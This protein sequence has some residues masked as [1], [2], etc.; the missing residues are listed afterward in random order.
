MYVAKRVSQ[1]H[2]GIL[3]KH[4]IRKC[5]LDFRQAGGKGGCLEFAHHLAGNAG[6]LEFLR[7]WIY[8]SEGSFCIRPA[9]NRIVYL[10]MD[11]VQTSVEIGR[12][13]EEEE[14]VARLQAFVVP[15]DTLEEDHLHLPR[16]IV[17]DYAEAFCRTEFYRAAARHVVASAR[18][19]QGAA[20]HR[21]LDLN[22]GKVAADIPD[23]G[24]GCAVDVA[25]GIDA[26][27]VP[28]GLY[29]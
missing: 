2:Q 1:R 27:K 20:N 7:A 25:V 19:E 5:F 13:A 23:R 10:G 18:A 14:G 4:I 29:A 17:H 22:V 24:Y 6:I 8:A 9:D 15:F 28:E 3:L 11:H 21:A 26:E 16:A 12:F